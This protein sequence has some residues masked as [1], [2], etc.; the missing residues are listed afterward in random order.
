MSTQ[1][2]QP[3]SFSGSVR[4]L[5]GLDDYQ[6]LFTLLPDALVYA[7]YGSHDCLWRNMLIALTQGAT[8]EDVAAEVTRAFALAGANV[9]ETKQEVAPT[10]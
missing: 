3:A 2:P 1:T 10:K 6:Y 7:P 8:I 5:I 4:Q 9:P